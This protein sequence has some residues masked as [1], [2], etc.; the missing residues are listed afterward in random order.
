MRAKQGESLQSKVSRVVNSVLAFCIAYMIV[1]GIFYLS[2][3]L[4][5]K[6]MGFDSTVYYYAAKINQDL[7][8]WNLKNVVI[9]F[10]TGF[11]SVILTGV[12]SFVIFQN[13]KSKPFVINMILI[14]A[15]VISSSIIAAHGLI[16][17]LGFTYYNSPFY[18]SIT[19]VFAWL[20]IPEP[21]TYFIALGLLVFGAFTALFFNRPFLQLSYSYSKVNKRSRRLKYLFETA[22]I[23]YLIGSVVLVFVTFPYNIW[24]TLIYLGYVGIT[25]FVAL[26]FSKNVN[27]EIDEIVRYKNLQSV[28]FFLVLFF[29]LLLGFLVL[30]W[31][32]IY[33]GS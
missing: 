32:G 27:V 11:L 16:L 12:L 6:I 25:L 20:R 15:T 18:I 14:W 2:T 22:F 30:T 28:N 33:L 3:G 26:T 29:F 24:V 8:E 5:G 19:I 9:I 13:I 21:L 17:V 23:P 7:V 4:M 1:I 31:K 10:S